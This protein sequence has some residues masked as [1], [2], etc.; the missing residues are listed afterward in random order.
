MAKLD[1]I[2]SKRLFAVGVD[3]QKTKAAK[4]SAGRKKQAP[5]KRR[6]R[7]LTPDFQPARLWAAKRKGR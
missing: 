1:G 7:R 2:I 3:L 5:G 6:P 4:A